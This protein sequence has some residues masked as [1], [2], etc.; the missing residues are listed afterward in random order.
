[1]AG[2]TAHRR[3]NGCPRCRSAW[4]SR[5]PRRR[6][7][8][9]SWCRPAPR[10][11]TRPSRATATRIRAEWR[12]G[13]GIIGCAPEGAGKKTG[14]RPVMVV[15]P[16]I[17]THFWI[18]ARRS[19]GREIG[20]QTS[21]GGLA[22]PSGRFRSFPDLRDPSFH[23]QQLLRHAGRSCI[24]AAQINP[25]GQGPRVQPLLVA[26]RFPPAG[27]QRRHLAAGH[28]IHRPGSPGPRAAGCNGWWCRR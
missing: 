10:S 28:V 11:G 19:G 17:L 1:M 22:G 4:S 14:R 23:D 15:L 21:G 13:R 24:Q 6:R 5:R 12:G 18:L 20:A 16:T 8:P 3:R 7:R 9:G 2:N 25:T 27:N 26:A